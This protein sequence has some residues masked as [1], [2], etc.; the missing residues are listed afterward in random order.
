MARTQ[1]QEFKPIPKDTQ[2]DPH[3]VKHG[4]CSCVHKEGDIT[5]MPCRDCKPG[6]LWLYWE[7]ANPGKSY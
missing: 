4:C 5:K 3:C 7:D 2:K 1:K 6:K